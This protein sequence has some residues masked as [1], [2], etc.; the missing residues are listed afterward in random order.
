MNTATKK[1]WHVWDRIGIL[2]FLLVAVIVFGILNPTIVFGPNIVEVISRSAL[3]AIAGAGMTF[4]ICSGGFDLSVGYIISLATC[5]FASVVQ[6]VGPWVALLITIVMGLV[7]GVLN[8]IIITKL[9]IQPFVATLATSMIFRGTALLYSD[10]RRIF[11][12]SY[13]PGKVFSTGSVLGIPMP[14]I[15]MVVVVIIAFLIYKF[16]PF[17][18]YTRSVGSNEAASR[19][20][21]IKADKV[22]IGVYMMTGAT[23]SITGVLYASQLSMGDQSFGA[24]F[25]LKAI[26]ATI[27]GGTAL[28]GGKGNVWGTF[29]GAILLTLVQVGLNM[30]SVPS[31][32]Q[33]LATG[34]ILLLALTINGIKII[35]MGG[36]E[37]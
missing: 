30:L 12:S 32:Y 3:I 33:D 20:T 4:A 17:G 18:V 13:E 34:L 2:I 10:G 27:L 37:Q 14:I 16:T 31:Q 36:E 11:F 24:G 19:V 1:F 26:T 23:A 22:L 29:L 8:G 7:C 28:S 6:T 35:T 15:L 5:V 25:E 9:Q 21:G